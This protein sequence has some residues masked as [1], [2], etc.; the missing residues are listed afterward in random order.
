MKKPGIVMSMIMAIDPSTRSWK[1]LV[2]YHKGEATSLLLVSELGV[3]KYVR[4]VKLS[5]D[6]ATATI[7]HAIEFANWKREKI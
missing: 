5:N 3:H 2:F 6:W 4:F 7:M 1:R